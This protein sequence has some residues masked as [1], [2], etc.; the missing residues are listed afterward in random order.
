MY[1][2]RDDIPLVGQSP[3]QNKLRHLFGILFDV[4]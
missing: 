2:L 1:M 4:S 3:E